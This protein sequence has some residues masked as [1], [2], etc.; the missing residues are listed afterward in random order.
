[1]ATTMVHNPLQIGADHLLDTSK[2]TVCSRHY[3]LYHC[4]YGILGYLVLGINRYEAADAQM[5][6]Q[7]P[8]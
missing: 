6:L 2:R 8:G 7:V 3:P 4:K 5:L 1:M